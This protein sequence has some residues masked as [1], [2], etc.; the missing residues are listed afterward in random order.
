MRMPADDGGVASSRTIN[1]EVLDVVDDI[2]ANPGNFQC[3][4]LGQLLSP[5]AIVDI[6]P[7]RLRASN[8][9]KVVEDRRS[10]EPLARALKV[11]V[12]PILDCHYQKTPRVP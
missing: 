12:T 10:I 3:S 1:R 9:A 2:N 6:A 8:L 7:N 11:S 5:N 4:G